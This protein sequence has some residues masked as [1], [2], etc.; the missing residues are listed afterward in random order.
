MPAHTHV[1]PEP[2]SLALLASGLLALACI[3][4]RR[5]G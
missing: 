4:R 3:I 1:V 2:S 5:R